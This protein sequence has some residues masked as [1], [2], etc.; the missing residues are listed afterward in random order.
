M[1]KCCNHFSELGFC[2]L[3]C[4]STYR[5][6]D[7]PTKPEV[8]KKC[9][10]L[11]I[12]W[13]CSVTVSSYLL[14]CVVVQVLSVFW[15]HVCRWWKRGQSTGHWLRPWHLAL[16]S[17]RVFMCDSVGRTWSVELSPIAITFFTTRQWTRPL[18]GP[19]AISTPTRLPTQSATALCPSTEFLVSFLNL[20]S[21]KDIS[22]NSLVA[23]ELKR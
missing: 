2:Y 14:T 18:T 13:S 22:K 11:Y 12:N 1:L 4:K 9:K 6:C 20:S 5:N 3:T 15:R 23:D 10:N 21:V 17:R 19:S 7:K 16:C 8:I